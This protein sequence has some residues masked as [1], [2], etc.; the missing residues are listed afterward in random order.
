MDK[1]KF[2]LTEI[3]PIKKEATSRGFLFQF[4]HG[5]GLAIIH[6]RNRPKLA[7]GQKVK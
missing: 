7:R 3:L 6:K 4:C 1:K 5:S 2:L